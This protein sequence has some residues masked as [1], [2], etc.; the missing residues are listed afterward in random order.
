MIR[1]SEEQRLLR[2]STRRLMDRHAPP[3]EVRRLDE[4]R[5]YPYDLYDAWVEAGLL[6]LPFPAAYGGLGGSVPDLVVV[7]REIAYTSPDLFMAYAG[8]VFCGL[9]IVAMG[10]DEQRAKWVEKLAKGEARMAIA[11]SEP[12]AGS[13]VG[14][15]RTRAVRDGESWVLNGCKLWSTGAGARET[16]INTYVRTDPHADHRKGLSLLLVDNDAPGVRCRKLDMLGRR[17][18]GTFEV[19]FDDVCVPGARLIGEIDG[20]WQVALAGLQ[21]E[22]I[23]SAA[24]N[25]GAAQ[26]VVDMAAQYAQER[27]QFGRP[28]GA[29][30]AVAHP[31]ADMATEVAAATA[32]TWAAAERVA[33]GEDALE[34]IT[35]AKLKS[36]ET[37]AA[38]ANRGM[39]VMGAYGY[40]MEYDM[41]RFFR[42]SRSATI[43]AGTSEMQRSLIARLMGLKV[44]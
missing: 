9:N 12:D 25:C 33:A 2:D 21:V 36:S 5:E 7:A 31:I 40:S 10:S 13:D 24:G 20:G 15:I 16:V 41:Q 17:S 43:A 14:A 1:L 27:T 29:N 44:R 38:V 28:I 3:E 11:M 37:F 19:T 26:R 30:Q 34:L 42:D 39:Q 6:A 35:M 32:L 22:R 4:A 8:S 23:V 18:V